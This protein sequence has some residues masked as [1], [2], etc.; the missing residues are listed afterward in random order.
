[1]NAASYGAI[2][3]AA[4]KQLQE[5]SGPPGLSLIL[6]AP[7]R[8]SGSGDGRANDFRRQPHIMTEYGPSDITADEVFAGRNVAINIEDDPT[9]AE[10]STAYGVVKLFKD[11]TQAG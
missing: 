9:L 2:N 8:K 5:S 6:R 1:L 11:W 4:K 7:S 3:S 10:G